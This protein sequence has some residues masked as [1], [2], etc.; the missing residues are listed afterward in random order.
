[1]IDLATA[2]AGTTGDLRPYDR[3]AG[4]FRAFRTYAG[5]TPGRTD[6]LAGRGLGKPPE[7]LGG[8]KNKRLI[9]GI[10]D[11]INAL[12]NGAKR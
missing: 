9:W 2:C 3:A 10:P 5:V 11:S 6:D 1:M 4:F 7:S 12:L 8:D